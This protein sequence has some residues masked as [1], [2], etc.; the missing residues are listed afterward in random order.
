MVIT[1]RDCTPPLGN[2]GWCNQPL[3]VTWRGYD[4]DGNHAC[5][6]DCPNPIEC[7]QNYLAEK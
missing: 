2:C 7:E 3:A 5:D 1:C 4:P 6:K